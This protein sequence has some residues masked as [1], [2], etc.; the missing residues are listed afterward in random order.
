[1]LVHSEQEAMFVACEMESTA[2]QLYTRALQ[3][4]DQLGRKNDPVY[5]AIE[6][7]L[8]EEK[9]HLFRFRSLYH[10]LDEADEQQLSLAA[11]GEGLLFEGGLMGAARQ[12]LLKDPES[13]LDLAIASERASAQKYR[14]FALAAQSEEARQALLL[15]AGEEEG[16]LMELEATAEAA[17]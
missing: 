11:I 3:L 17:Q 14:E 2:V 9:G 15:I 1:M 7:M 5:P 6:K 4:L 8:M 16:H 13:L 12:G 10:G